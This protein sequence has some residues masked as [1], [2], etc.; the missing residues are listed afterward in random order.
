MDR[1]VGQVIVSGP[2]MTHGYFDEPEETKVSFVDGW[3]HTGDLGYLANGELFICGR[4]KDLIII[5]GRNYYPQDIERVASEAHNVRP[6]QCIA[7]GREGAAGEEC[8]VVIEGL[9]PARDV[10]KSSREIIKR[11]RTELGRAGGGGGAH[12][13]QYHPQNLQ[14]QGEAARNPRAAIG[15]RLAGAC[16]P[17]CIRRPRPRRPRPRRPSVRG[18]C[19]RWLA[20]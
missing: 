19:R 1:Q 6:D 8:V 5:N 9:G 16:A 2:S 20:A 4:A 10:L 14:R 13:P 18:P 7:F 12:S 3:L 11:V 17:V 15:W